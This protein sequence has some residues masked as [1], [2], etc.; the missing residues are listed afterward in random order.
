MFQDFKLFFGKDQV[1]LSF[2]RKEGKLFVQ[3]TY[4][5]SLHKEN[6]AHFYYDENIYQMKGYEK[7]LVVKNE[8]SIL[9]IVLEKDTELFFEVEVSYK[10][11]VKMVYLFINEWID[12]E[13]LLEQM[14]FFIEML[15]DRTE[16]EKLE[17]LLLQIKEIQKSYG[18]ER[19]WGKIKDLLIENEVYFSYVKKME[20][21]DLYLLITWFI[22]MPNVPSISQEFF[23]ELVEA[24]KGY[25][26]S[27]EGLWR[28]AMNYDGRGYDFSS[29]SRFFLEAKDAWY[30]LEYLSVANQVSR[31]EMVDLLI[32]TGDKT[33][34]KAV[35]EDD[36]AKAC[37]SKEILEKLKNSL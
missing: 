10:Y 25:V 35:Y 16:Q 33:F 9:E 37:F 27:K 12:V 1:E 5:S 19:A 24:G 21:L 13:V 20:A 3:Y 29:L 26:H 17:K 11:F 30:F 14:E 32:A 28:L 8:G 15:Q 31:E 7:Y 23:E 2:E 18:K 22:D 4:S 34:M 6:I 36:Y